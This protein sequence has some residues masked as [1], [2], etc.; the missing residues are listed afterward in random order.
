LP[1]RNFLTFRFFEEARAAKKFFDLDHPG[2]KIVLSGIYQ[3]YQVITLLQL[4]P[5]QAVSFP[6]HPPGAVPLNSV[7]ELPGKGKSDP[8]IRPPVLQYQQPGA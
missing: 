7:S 6:A 4:V 3:Q 5:Q 1:S 8:V 2:R